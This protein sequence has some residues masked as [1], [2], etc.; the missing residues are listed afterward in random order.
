MR[1]VFVK[2]TGRLTA[3]MKLVPTYRLLF[4]MTII[5][6]PASLLVVAIVSA[7]IPAVALVV[8]FAGAVAADAYRSKGRLQQ[9]RIRLP[10]VIRLSQG[11]EGQLEIQIENRKMIVRRLRL[12]LALPE[13]IDAP[14]AEMM[15]ALPKDN[16][17]SSVSW[18]LKGLKQGRFHL[19]ACYLE[20][21]TFWGFWTIRT[22]AEVDVD[23]RVYP[24]L[25]D[26]RKNLSGLFLNRGLGIHA[27]RQIGKG[28]DFEQLRDYLPGDSFEDIH[29]KTTA[30]RGTAITKVYQIERTQQIYVV[31]D[32][33]R[34]SARSAEFDYRPVKSNAPAPARNLTTMLQRFITAALIMALAAQRQGDLFGLL[35]FDDKVRSYLKAK[36]GKAH[37][38]VCRDAIYTLQP[39]SVSPDFAELFTFIRTKI[40]RR[41]LLIFLTHLDDPILA[42]GFTQNI[43]IISRPHVVVVNMFK[44]AAAAPLFSSESISSV[45]EIYNALGG[46]LLWRRL[47]ETHKVFQRHGVGFNMLDNE[48]LCT[49][50]VSQYLTLKRRQVL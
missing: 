16:P 36:T 1:G 32:S 23:V 12:G 31:I 29:W 2:T 35:T 47:R 24:N 42:G 14:T 3:R 9:V 38:D 26:E 48:T 33:S 21:A 15:V 37:F 13:A 8:L 39:R 30:K 43:E 50:M 22:A 49:D 46:H 20:T 18:P 4:W 45:N 11:R 6:V 27:Q 40:R 17:F 41:A 5:F 19:D 7:V 34:L 44:P 25:F 28:R 10:E